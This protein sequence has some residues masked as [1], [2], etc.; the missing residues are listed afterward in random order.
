MTIKNSPS[1]NIIKA[2]TGYWAFIPHPL[3]PILDWNTPL[4]SC[5]SRADHVLGMLAREG[6]APQSPSPYT[7][8]YHTRS[9]TF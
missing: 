4:V 7:T 2:L 3:P 8:F 9:G 1:G 6:A 5:L